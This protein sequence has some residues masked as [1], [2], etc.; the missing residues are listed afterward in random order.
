MTRFICCLLPGAKLTVAYDFWC[1][2]VCEFFIIA[3]SM[4]CTYHVHV[5]CNI[6][7]W[8]FSDEAS[9]KPLEIVYVTNITEKAPSGGAKQQGNLLFCRNWFSDHTINKAFWWEVKWNG[10]RWWWRKWFESYS[11]FC[12]F[13][14]AILGPTELSS[15]NVCIYSGSLALSNI[16]VHCA[17]QQTYCTLSWVCTA[18]DYHL[19]VHCFSSSH[20]HSLSLAIPSWVGVI[21]N[22]YWQWPWLALW[23]KRQVLCSKTA[24]ILT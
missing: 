9:K 17:C 3:W 8:M 18:M 14:Q 7:A 10:R 11:S 19:Q 20:P 15:L 12:Y 1:S 16:A 23:K 6:R 5:F 13:L 4:H 24:G 2:A 22:K 21:T